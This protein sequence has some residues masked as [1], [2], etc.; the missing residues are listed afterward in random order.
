MID[1][2]TPTP[3]AK[4]IRLEVE[5][6]EKQLNKL[7]IKSRHYTHLAICGHGIPNPRTFIKGKIVGTQPVR[8]NKKAVETLTNSEAQKLVDSGEAEIPKD[9]IIEEKPECEI[10]DCIW[11]DN[12][13]CKDPGD[14]NGVTTTIPDNC[15]RI[16]TKES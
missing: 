6:T 9:A 12:G 8:K 14:L 3:G 10:K 7:F 11:F 4:T 1:K 2:S 15:P 5:L 16:I 13:D